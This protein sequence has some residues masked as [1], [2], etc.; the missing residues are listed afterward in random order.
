MDT[1]FTSFDCTVRRHRFDKM[2]PEVEKIASDGVL[3]YFMDGKFKLFSKKSFD[4]Y[5][6]GLSSRSG[7]LVARRFLYQNSYPIESLEDLSKIMYRMSK[8]DGNGYSV[9]S[10]VRVSFVHS[11]FFIEITVGYNSDRNVDA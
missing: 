1:K 3:T 8:Y 10:N 4:E 11:D 5:I 9:H 7:S 2:A 6:N